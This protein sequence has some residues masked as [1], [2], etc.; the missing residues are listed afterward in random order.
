MNARRFGRKHE[1][2]LIYI[3]LKWVPC[4]TDADIRFKALMQKAV[5]VACLY[6]DVPT[7]EDLLGARIRYR[8]L[9][10]L[11]PHIYAV[12]GGQ[13]AAHPCRIGAVV[14]IGLLR[15]RKADGIVRC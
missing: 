7:A 2:H 14:G 9:D 11:L 12:E 13:A 4:K 5:A 10:D 8:R 1:K 6:A 15:Q 3:Q